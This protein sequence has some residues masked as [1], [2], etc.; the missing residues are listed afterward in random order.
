MGRAASEFR[1]SVLKH[2]AIQGKA[3]ALNGEKQ[4]AGAGGAPG[5]GNWRVGEKQRRSASGQGRNRADG[6]VGAGEGRWG[7][8]GKVG[9]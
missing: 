6:L 5:R 3:S 1:S 8:L 7:W 2:E 4:G 9:T